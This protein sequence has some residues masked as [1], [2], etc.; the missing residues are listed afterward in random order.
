MS[1]TPA[2]LGAL[3][4]V[5]LVFGF[6]N[7]IVGAFGAGIDPLWVGGNLAV[8]ALLLAV[9]GVRSIE[10]LRERL[11]SGAT[12]RAGRYGS[13]AILATVFAVAILWLLGFLATR[14]PL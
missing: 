8:G 10:S 5:A 11:A 6:L 12:R 4:L 1:G 14:Y 2:L 7:L 3:G 13:S 9:A